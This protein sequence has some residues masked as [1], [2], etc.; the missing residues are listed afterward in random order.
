MRIHD[1]MI[2]HVRKIVVY[3]GR[4]DLTTYTPSSGLS[5]RYQGL[6][7][8]HKTWYGDRPPACGID[9]GAPASEFEIAGGSVHLQP[10]QLSIDY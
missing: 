6:G 2:S 9:I 8:P 1:F 7:Y 4:Q 5:V 3:V 10:K